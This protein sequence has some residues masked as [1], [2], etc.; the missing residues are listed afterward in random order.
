LS[1]NLADLAHGR[2]QRRRERDRVAG[3]ADD[4]VLVVEEAGALYCAAVDRN[5]PEKMRADCLLT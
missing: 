4:E 3:D 2:N 5:K 1:K